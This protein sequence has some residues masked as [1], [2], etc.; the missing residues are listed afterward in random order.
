MVGRTP[1]LFLFQLA[2]AFAM[3]LAAAGLT[4]APEAG[5]TFPTRVLWGDT[6]LH[7]RLSIDANMFGN[8]RLGPAE[9]YRFAR[10]EAVTANSGQRASLARPL[11]FLAVTDHGE[12]L[13]LIP[14]VQDNAPELQG[15]ELTRQWKTALAD[16]DM[17]TLMQLWSKGPERVGDTV[18]AGPQFMGRIWRDYAAVA[19]RYNVP[20]QF[21]TFIAYEWTGM[22]GMD[23]L[24]RN[25]LF[26][27]DAKTV[28]AML[29]FTSRDSQDPGELWRYLEAY[30]TSTGGRAAAIPHNSNLSGGRMFL[31][32]TA[33]G[34]PIDRDYAQRRAR[35]EPIV[36]IT[37]IKGDSETH[38]L[39]SPGDKFA[40]FGRWDTNLAM[41]DTVRPSMSQYP[42]NYVRSALGIGL[43]IER[44]VGTNPFRFGVVGSTDSHT[45]LSTADDDNF[46][47][48]FSK[49]EP[50]S[51]RAVEPVLPLSVS[52]AE[53]IY[54][55]HRLLASG[56]A[57]VWAR[58]NTRE[59]IFD[60]LLRR[61]VYATTGPRITV[62]FFAGWGFVAQDAKG[63]IAAVGYDK[64]VPMGGNLDSAPNAG[65]PRFLLSALRD[66]EG[67]NLDRVQ[68]IKGWVD[69]AGQRRERVFDVLL[70][71]GRKPAADGEVP[72]VGNTVDIAKATYSNSIG[73]AELQG[74][75]QDPDFDAAVPAYYYL[76]VLEIPTPGWALYDA[77]RF[78]SAPSPSA[79]LSVQQRAYTSA[80]WYTP[81]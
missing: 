27:D 34:E 17:A 73:T 36:E 67:A 19:D 41:N 45:A 77:A 39:L 43:Q 47:G 15:F 20:G 14:G 30:E 48:K 25:V 71:G 56:M 1:A 42:F 44:E 35:W 59:A 62:R 49:D 70:S 50:H 68:V 63:D 40:D 61:E 72:A 57:A 28:T 53:G 79:Q 22:A 5:D 38:P 16:G 12:F 81:D 33:S 31:D 26:A 76:R 18:F 51:G 24:H 37:Q 60:A 69:A 13:G 64:G 74:W 54:P 6:H 23:N 55:N 7:T 11:D 9:A 29:P 65:A 80:I 78:G 46:W 4:A 3:S 52:G 66:P 2:M 58:A 10:G 21:T 32:R 8:S 75:W